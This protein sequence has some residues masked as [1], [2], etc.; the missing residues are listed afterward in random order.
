MPDVNKYTNKQLKE[1]VLNDWHALNS[2]LGDLTASTIYKCLV[3][4]L[5]GPRRIGF[6][7]RLHTRFMSVRKKELEETLATLLEAC[8]SHNYGVKQTQELLREAY[9]L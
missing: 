9:R 6:V 1:T 2:V 3:L 8:H 7:Q 4:E 5:S